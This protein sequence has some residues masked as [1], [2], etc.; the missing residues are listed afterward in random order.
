MRVVP[1]NAAKDSKFNDTQTALTRALVRADVKPT[2]EKWIAKP[3]ADAA[4]AK[5]RQQAATKTWTEAAT[6]VAAAMALL[7]QTVSVIRQFFYNAGGRRKSD[8]MIKVLFVVA[9][10][11][12]RRLPPSDILLKVE[13]L[14]A[15]IERTAHPNVPPAL[16]KEKADELRTLCASLALKVEALDAAT[17]AKET[18]DA[19]FASAADVC[20]LELASFKRDL[21]AQKMSEAAIHE[22]IPTYAPTKRSKRK[23]KATANGDGRLV[24]DTAVAPLP[25]SAAPPASAPSPA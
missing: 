12:L 5:E 1:V 8:M 22:I 25:A 13:Q 21:R 24:A 20:Q 7:F 6:I 10:G 2:A 9:L 15:R 4:F 14:A 3:V 18:A 16:T 19:A 17:A 11:K 23:A